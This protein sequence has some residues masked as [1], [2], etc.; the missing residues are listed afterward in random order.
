MP[1]FAIICSRTMDKTVGRLGAKNLCTLTLPPGC[2]PLDTLSLT[3]HHRK[4]NPG[5]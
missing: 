4:S 2:L 5:K 3:L 1:P